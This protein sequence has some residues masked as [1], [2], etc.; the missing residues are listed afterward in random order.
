MLEIITILN[1]N[2]KSSNKSLK[3]ENLKENKELNDKI[4]NYFNE[5][6]QQAL[7]EVKNYCNN[8]FNNYSKFLNN[9]NYLKNLFYPWK[10]CCVKFKF[11]S[12]YEN[13]LTKNSLP[14]LRYVI[15]SDDLSE[16][17]LRYNVTIIYASDF[18]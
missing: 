1:K 17:E 16:T 7:T 9:P 2:D 10:R 4:I 6:F 15:Y 3:N 13:I 12:I 14:L 11:Y 8:K 18:H 5:F